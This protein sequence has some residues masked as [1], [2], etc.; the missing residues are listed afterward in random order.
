ML[1][2]D[3]KLKISTMS[4]T[5]IA[6]VITT[7]GTLVVALLTVF[8]EEIISFRKNTSDLQD[9][10]ARKTVIETSEILPSQNNKS[11]RKRP[12]DTSVRI[13]KAIDDSSY[14][15]YLPNTYKGIGGLIFTIAWLIGW[16]A[17]I[18]FAAFAFVSMLLGENDGG[19]ELFGTVFM[20]AWLAGAI[21]GE[22]MVIKQIKES[23][24]KVLGKQIISV[25]GNLLCFT[26][27]IFGIDIT[28]KYTIDNIDGFSIENS[29]F[30]FRYGKKRIPITDL[31]ENEVEWIKPQLEYSIARL[32]ELYSP[33]Q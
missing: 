1:G 21:A 25:S 16:T 12:F 14:I 5:V 17:G 20:G 33:N 11:S 23:L 32:L 3:F 2:A 15:F 7:F 19:I 26:D 18:A 8:K 22:F 30:F 28:R 4:D 27:R 9:V 6:A 13:E 29:E 31:T 24:L 10:I